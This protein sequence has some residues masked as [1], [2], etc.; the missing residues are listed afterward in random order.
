MATFPTDIKE[1]LRKERT[2]Q[3]VTQALQ[4][5]WDA[6]VET[7]RSILQEFPDDVETYNRLGKALMELGRNKEAVE[8]FKKALQHS[9]HNAIARKNLDRLS[10]IGE[11]AKKVP[12]KGTAAPQTFIQESGKAGRTSLL[13]LAPPK[14]L[15]K[16]SPGDVVELKLEGIALK[17]TDAAGGYI[18]QV[19]P[20]LSSRLAKLIKGGN[21]Y[22][23]SVASVGKAELGIIIREKY[24]HPSQAGIVSFPTKGTVERVAIPSAVAAYEAADGE[25]E[26]EVEEAEKTE[27][28]DW[29]NDDTEPGDDEAFSPML[30]RIIDAG[31]EAGGEEEEEERE[32]F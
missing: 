16:L 15:L 9:P 25:E 22:E 2:R 11:R 6:A 1:R 12:V 17:V 10:Q 5:Q 30:H 13:N 23:A 3:A 18:G 32:E 26:V 24:Q 8:A 29:S 19:E 28:K 14:M 27:V 7:N 31:G 21:R 20:K 4:S